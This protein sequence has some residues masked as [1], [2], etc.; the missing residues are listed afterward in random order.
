MIPRCSSIKVVQTVPVCSISRSRCQKIGFQIAI[1]KNLWNCKAQSFHIWYITSSRGP[2][3]KLF[4]LCPWGQNWPHPGGHN[5]TLNYIGRTSNDLLKGIWPNSTEMVPWWSSTTKCRGG[6]A[7]MD[8]LC[9]VDPS[10]RLHYC[11][12]SINP[13]IGFISNLAK[14]FYSTRGCAEP[15]LPMCQLKVKV[16]IEGQILDIISCPLCK[17]YTN[18]KIF[19]NLGSNVHLNK[20]MCRTHVTFVPA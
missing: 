4:K 16:T 10:V 6:G 1:L 9:S 20:G 14:M 3:P 12:R 7:I 17:S 2:L 15:M 13:C 5:F 8:S 19:F 18:W 11:V